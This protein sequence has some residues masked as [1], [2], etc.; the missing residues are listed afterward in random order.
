MGE[1]P[2][3]VAAYV[4]S[5]LAEE[6]YEDDSVLLAK[7]LRAEGVLA[8]LCDARPSSRCP[9][10]PCRAVDSARQSRGREPADPT[11]T[12]SYVAGVDAD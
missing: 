1:R 6:M 11:R 10:C 9:N 2:I 8:P 4:Q 3:C 7:R 12:G 5:I